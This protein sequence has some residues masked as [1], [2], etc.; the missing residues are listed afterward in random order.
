VGRIDGEEDLFLL[1]IVNKLARYV[2][3]VAVED[4]EALLP[5]R[6]C[7]SLALENLL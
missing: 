7:C 3:A 4:K 6:F 5:A 2:A 1:A